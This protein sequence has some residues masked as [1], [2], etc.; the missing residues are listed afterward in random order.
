AIS[1]AHRAFVLR[2]SAA[3]Q[4]ESGLHP[5]G[6]VSRF[7]VSMYVHVENAWTF[8]E[9]VIMKSRCLKSVSEQSGHDRVHFV[10][11][12][13]KVSHHDV[14]AAVALRHREPASEAEWRGCGDTVDR[15]LKIVAGDVDLQDIRFEIAL[16]AQCLEDTF[17]VGGHGLCDYGASRKDQS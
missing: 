3:D 8:E 13:D 2:F 12:Q 1:P 7:S 17:V 11:Q 14:R 5:I 6:Q 10:F 4:S 9:E 15:H 16:L